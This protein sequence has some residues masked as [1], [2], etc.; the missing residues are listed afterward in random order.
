M[1]EWVHKKLGEYVVLRL[2]RPILMMNLS[3]LAELTMFSTQAI[4]C[5]RNIH[6]QRLTVIPP[7]L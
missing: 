6:T 2:I 1:G 3:V 7:D 5:P 4:Q